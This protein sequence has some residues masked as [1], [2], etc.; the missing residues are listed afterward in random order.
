[1]DEKTGGQLCAWKGAGP[2]EQPCLIGMSAIALD[3]LNLCAHPIF[4][5]KNAHGI[6][7]VL[8]MSP[9]RVDGLIADN[10][11]RIRWVANI[12]L[13]V[14]QNPATFG[15]ATGAENNRRF[16][17]RIELLTA[18]HVAHIFQIAIVKGRT[19]AAIVEK[20]L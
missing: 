3:R 15:H 2:V 7:P 18:A 4:I 10:E 16:S 9:Q 12:I 8:Q 13:Q 19:L 5:A 17:Q 6:G 14:M 11:D 1:M 20:A